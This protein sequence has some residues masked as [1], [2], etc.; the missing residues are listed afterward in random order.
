MYLAVGI[1]PCTG[2]WINNGKGDRMKN[3]LIL[4]SGR[5]GTSMLG[6]ILHQAGYF[7]GDMLHKPRESNPKGFFEWYK[8]NKIN[9]NILAN[10]LKNSFTIRLLK[11]VLKKNVIE[12]PG[13]N[14]RWL[15]S[16]PLDTSVNEINPQVE[17]EI[18]EVIKRD[19]FCYKDPRFSYTLPVW[20]RYLNPGTVFICVFR[21]PDVTVESILKECRSQ[22]YLS[23]LYIDRRSAYR[24]WMSIYSHILFKH[25]RGSDSGNFL[26]VHYNQVYEGT[27]IPSLSAFL[28]TQLESGFVDKNLKRTTPVGKVP[29]RAQDIYKQ[30]CQRA[31]Y[32]S[33]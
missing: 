19:P 22:D 4:G 26:F 7:M 33:A 1:S 5:S 17:R 21:E 12:N 2:L 23:D 31:N 32:R 9:E 11:K 25:A 30:L 13:K 10:Y 28:D 18:E 8:I 3:C 27:A 29:G 6:G 15:L 20:R 16:L 14:Q 24:V